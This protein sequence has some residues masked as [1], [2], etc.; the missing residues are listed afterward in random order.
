RWAAA[1]VKGQRTDGSFAGEERAQPSGW[2]TAQQ[3][4]ALAE[5]HRA[6]DGAPVAAL[7]AGA[8][9]LRAMRVGGGWVG[10]RIAATDPAAPQP[11]TA[12]A[13]WAVLAFHATLRETKDHEAGLGE[14]EALAM[15]R[16]ARHPDG[17][18]HER[19]M[20]KPATSDPNR[21]ARPHPQLDPTHERSALYPTALAAWALATVGSGSV[22][23]AVSPDAKGALDWLSRQVANGEPD[24]RAVG[25]TEQLAFIARDADP[26][27]RIALAKELVVHC[28]PDAQRRGACARDTYDTGRVALAPDAGA[29]VTM[30]H[31]WTTLAAATLAKDA[32]LAADTRATLDGIARWGAQELTASTEVLGGL[33]AYKLS[34]YLMVV[35]ELLR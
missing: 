28:R 14:G 15:L 34:E 6:C 8:R 16:A 23:P 18:F 7:A 10:P 32:A 26:P 2:D 5:S 3:L 9:A 33:P 31:P 12:A 4:F 29:L 11:A 30:W 27:T 13:A 19:A 35:S 17:G 20:T 25:F 21:P 22:E 1:L 24:T